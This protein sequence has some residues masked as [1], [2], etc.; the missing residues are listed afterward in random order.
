MGSSMK[1]AVCLMFMRLLFTS[2]PA[3][4]CLPPP[5]TQMHPFLLDLKLQCPTAIASSPPIEIDGELLD[6]MLRS[7]KPNTYTVVLFYASWC[8]FSKIMQPK[9]DALA[10][11]YPQMKHVKIEQSSNLPTVFSIH[12]IHSV[13][14]IVIASKTDRVHYHGPKDLHSLSEFYQTTTGLKYA[15]NITE[16]DDQ[17]YSSDE[18]TSRAL[19]SWKDEPYL[20]FSLLFVSLKVVFLLCPNIVSNVVALWVT[21][22]PRLNLAIFG[23][24]RQLLTHALHLFNVKSVFGKFTITKSRNFH[25]GARGARVLAS[26]LASVS[27]GESSSA[28][29]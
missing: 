4:A 19:Q 23:E 13:P 20:L 5:Q 15:M 10:L 25:H 29:E 21:Y 26:S 6:S 16:D 18:N 7:S 17:W 8:P 24:S 22:I 11:M 27:L 14:S 3:L 1:L 2:S 12:G 9:F 28:R